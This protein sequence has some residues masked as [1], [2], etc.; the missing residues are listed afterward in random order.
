M[1]A[2]K[3]GRK[4]GPLPVWAWAIAVAGGLVLLY[5]HQRRASAL[6]ATSSTQQ[7]G[8]GAGIDPKT[9]LPFALENID[10]QTGLPYYLTPTNAGLA[11]SAST[12]TPQ[13]DL[14]T[15]L[16]SLAGIIG[17]YQQL[18]T[19]FNPAF[20]QPATPPTPPATAAAP[21]PAPSV[22]KVSLRPG[23]S[24]APGVKTAVQG[25]AAVYHGNLGYLGPSG[26]FH[27]I[28]INGHHVAAPKPKAKHR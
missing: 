25:A 7:S 12:P 18:G 5:I 10:P 2:P 14:A 3:L 15:Q 8:Q 4:V 11:S 17:A 13:Q 16:Q 9:G 6:T 21:A 23:V 20:P 19:L 24:L 1:P 26:G 28:I 27:P 22:Q